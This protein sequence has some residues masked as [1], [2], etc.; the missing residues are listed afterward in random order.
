MRGF[1]DP[2]ADLGPIASFLSQF[3]LVPVIPVDRFAPP[4]PGPQQ[5]VALAQCRTVSEW[6][7]TRYPLN[8][9]DIPAMMD[10]NGDA[11]DGDQDFV[12]LVR[13]QD[14]PLARSV[15]QGAPQSDCR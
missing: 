5:W 1:A 9:L 10:A 4:P 12:L 11:S 3:A 8:T 14:L 13:K 7:S 2:L 15:L 6:H